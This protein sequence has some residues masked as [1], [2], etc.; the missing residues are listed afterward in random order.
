MGV[1]KD[2]RS[3]EMFNK[4]VVGMGSSVHVSGMLDERSFA[5]RSKTAA[6]LTMLVL[7]HQLLFAIMHTPPQLIFPDYCSVHAV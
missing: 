3:C 7:L 4:I 2:S 5:K 1:I 6:R